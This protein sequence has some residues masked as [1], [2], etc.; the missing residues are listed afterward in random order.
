MVANKRSQSRVTEQLTTVV[1]AQFLFDERG[2]AGAR[3]RGGGGEHTVANP[4]VIRFPK[5]PNHTHDSWLEF[6]LECTIINHEC[7]SS[8]D[9]LETEAQASQAR[10]TS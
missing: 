7:Q 1:A 3:G 9:R 10:R 5:R 4:F 8:E 6:R 2:G